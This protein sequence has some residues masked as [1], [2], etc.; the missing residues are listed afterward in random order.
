MSQS[1]HWI[2]YIRVSNTQFS[3]NAHQTA[4]ILVYSVFAQQSRACVYHSRHVFNYILRRCAMVSERDYARVKVRAPRAIVTHAAGKQPSRAH[5]LLGWC[6]PINQF[7]WI[8]CARNRIYYVVGVYVRGRQLRCEYVCPLLRRVLAFCDAID[9]V[10]FGPRER[11]SI[12]A[13]RF[14][15]TPRSRPNALHATLVA[16]LTRL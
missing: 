12:K 9:F 6:A 16:R 7:I 1:L 14:H 13:Q 5:G 10:C 2:Y 11:K 4:Y 15:K 8:C 3:M